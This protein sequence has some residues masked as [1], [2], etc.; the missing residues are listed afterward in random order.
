MIYHHLSFYIYHQNV[1]HELFF[2]ITW[3]ANFNASQNVRKF[4]A[5]PK[6]NSYKSGFKLY[7]LYVQITK[8]Q[9]R[10]VCWPLYCR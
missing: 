5:N 1:N 10:L 2:Y 9:M 3:H 7:D 4:Y 6:K 8:Q